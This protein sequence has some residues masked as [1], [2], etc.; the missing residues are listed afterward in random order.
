[1]P[2][3]I[4]I[5]I[6]T[7]AVFGVLFVAY[8][9]LRPFSSYWPTTVRVQTNMDSLWLDQEEKTCVSYPDNEGKIAVVHCGSSDSSKSDSHNIPVTFWGSI[10]RGKSSD[11]KCQKE[12]EKFVCR[13][14]D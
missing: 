3:A 9:S 11:W 12:S 4:A 14:T 2:K 7:L 8:E 1:M 13:A 6:V 10:D 5:L